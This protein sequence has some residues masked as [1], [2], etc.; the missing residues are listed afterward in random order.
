MVW[1]LLK[2][3]LAAA[4]GHKTSFLIIFMNSPNTKKK[5]LVFFGSSILTD[6]ELRTELLK[7][8]KIF[9]CEQIQFFNG[10]AQDR[11]IH[12]ILFEI[13][14]DGIELE[15][16][17]RLITQYEK[18]PVIVVGRIK[19]M[20]NVAKAFEIGAQDFFRIPYKIKLLVEK[21]CTIVEKY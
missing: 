21:A 1:I 16:L 15:I 4:K 5:N 10:I 12:L 8:F 2:L 14:I 13:G 19:T 20:D 18:I 3:Y 9:S 17:Q 7:Y 11:Q 6:A